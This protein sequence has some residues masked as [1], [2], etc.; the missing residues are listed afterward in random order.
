M[1]T[2]ILSSLVMF[3]ACCTSKE[4][5]ADQSPSAPPPASAPKKAPLEGTTTVKPGAPT[6]LEAQVTGTTA[7]LSLR[8][9]GAGEEVVARVS[10]LDGVTVSA[11]G[12]WL[13]GASVKA[14]EVREHT[15]T[16]TT[17][18]RGHLVISVEGRF[19]GGLKA[20]VHTVAVGEGPV[21]DL[22]T[23]QQTTDGDTVKVMP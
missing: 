10:G 20:R 1:R 11:G 21:K 5:T 4:A 13:A 18:G 7:R 19:P 23:V 6:T 8:F 16:F 3:A 9:D 22:G 17:S 14:G 15:V 12:E 2:L